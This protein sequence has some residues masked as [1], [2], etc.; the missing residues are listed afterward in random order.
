MNKLLVKPV[1]F[2]QVF[3]RLISIVSLFILFC[4]QTYAATTGM[5]DINTSG[6][7]ANDSSWSLAVS[8]SGKLM[9]FVSYATNLDAS[10]GANDCFCRDLISGDLDSFSC[11]VTTT[12]S[13]SAD[14]R[15][16]AHGG[17]QVYVYDRETQSSE[18]ISVSTTGQPGNYYSGAPVISADGRYVA[19]ASTATDLI[20]NDTNGDP[21]APGTFGLDYFLRDRQAGTT[22]RISVYSDGSEMDSA[23]VHRRYIDMSPDGRYFS[24]AMGLNTYIP[25]TTASEGIIFRDRVGNV[26]EYIGEGIQYLSAISDDGRYVATANSYPGTY[27][28]QAVIFDRLT[29]TVR[30]ASIAPD[31]SPSNRIEVVVTDMSA[32]GRYVLYHNGGSNL[33]PNDT[34]SVRDYFLFDTVN[35]T[36]EMVSVANDGTIENG[37]SSDFAKMTPDGTLIGFPSTAT[38]LT[39][40]T[41]T[42]MN[43]IYYRDKANDSDGD[44]Y[45]YLAGVV[46]DD[47]DDTNS[48]INPGATEI[49]NNGIDENCSGMADDTDV[50][51]D[52][53]GIGDDCN[54]NNPLAYPGAPEIL[55]NGADE[56][57]N[58]LADDIDSDGDLFDATQ[59]CDDSDLSSYPGAAEVIADGIDQ[60]CN[61]YDLS[62][63]ITASY[64]ANKDQLTVDATSSLGA[65]ANL[66][67]I[68]YGPMTYSSNKWSIIV[69]PAGG[70]PGTVT[71]SGVE[72]AATLSVQ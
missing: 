47:C 55:N 49:T 34:N 42:P 52:G 48:A 14:D 12:L 28:T 46:N 9:C 30:L 17:S 35:N 57:C 63:V 29:D 51:Q 24:F 31:G 58:G 15:Y 18:L 56:N 19:F 8:P 62:I 54:D 50:D 71:V 39:T 22:T 68:G 59:D 3:T 5:I 44:K 40:T 6:E 38:N 1:L 64:K 33:V 43:H 72:G 10:A 20:A 60:D 32:D 11:D 16:V 41:V 66:T 65:A 7:A 70:S 61:G 2:L 4:S 23:R 26:T 36:N 21:T 25:G 13:I 69:E 67:L 37:E 53:Y 45:R 27:N